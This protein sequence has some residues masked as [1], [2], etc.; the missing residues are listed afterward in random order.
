M[1]LSFL[2]LIPTMAMNAVLPTPEV[3]E[4]P[5]QP[6]DFNFPKR[7]FGKSTIVK[8]SFQASWF[9]QHNWLHYD[10]ERDIAFCHTCMKA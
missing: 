9:K 5:H 8:R 1:S 2:Q 3:G 4:N 10:E 6:S 7:E